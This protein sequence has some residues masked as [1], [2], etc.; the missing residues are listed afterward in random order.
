MADIDMLGGSGFGMNHS[1]ESV[2]QRG[3]SAS[4]IEMYGGSDM[5]LTHT[6]V[7]SA[8]KKGGGGDIDMVG[9]QGL[10]SNEHVTPHGSQYPSDKGEA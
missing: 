2:V 10:I 1:E 4:G 9:L 3:G 5:D 6:P 8:Q 7:P